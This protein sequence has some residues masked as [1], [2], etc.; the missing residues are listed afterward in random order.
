M[1]NVKIWSLLIILALAA[2][3]CR[4]GE[5]K[6]TV[7]GTDDDLSEIEVLNRSIGQDTSNASLLNERAR[8]HLEQ[9]DVNKALADINAALQ[10]EPRNATYYVTLSDI[11][12]TMGKLNNCIEALEKA[13]ELDPENTA[14]LLKQA[15]VYLILRE[16]TRT[17]DYVKRALEI[18]DY[19]PVAYFIRG[20]TLLETGDTLKA[21]RDFMK[22]VEQDQQ[23][24]EAYMQLGLLYA[25]KNDPLAVGY[26]RNAINARPAD[27]EPYYFLGMYHQEN[28]DISRA[29]QAY[30]QLLTIDP[31]YVDAY[32]NLG[33]LNLVYLKDY[34]MAVRY[35]TDV[36]IRDPRRTEAWYNRGYAHEL[37]GDTRAARKDYQE[38]LD[39]TLNYPLAVEGMNRISVKR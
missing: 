22:A 7:P 37:S 2:T 9:G 4:Q 6:A 25:M 29:I 10:S 34:D 24:Y 23:Y 27:P 13:E 38:A 31:D 15:E 21:V 12:M 28:A 14:G 18:D 20:Y 36:V 3:S 39:V 19:N 35:F 32:Y 17:I 1:F 30:E 33:Y 5:R 8:Y 16:Y 11:Y 26:Y